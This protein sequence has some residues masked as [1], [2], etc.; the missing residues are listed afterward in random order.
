MLGRIAKGEDPAGERKAQAQRDRA[1]LEAALDLYERALE[2]RHVV[3]RG[4]YLS[5]LR[6][7]LLKPLGNVELQEI[8]RAT[9]A[10]RI[11]KI[12]AGRRPGAAKELKTRASVFLSWAVDEGMINANPLAGW[13][14]QRRTKAER[15]DRPGRALAD[16]ELPIFWKAAEAEG[17]PFGPYLQML[18]LTGQ[19]RT[20]TSLMRWSDVDLAAGEWRIPA[21][22]TKSGRTHRVP[23]PARAVAI[24]EKLPRLARS[25]Y[26]SPAGGASR[27]RA[28]QSVCRRSTVRPSRPE[29]RTGHRMTSDGPCAQDWAGSASTRSPPS[30]CYNHAISEELQAVYDRGDYWQ[31]RV[32][33][34]AQWA[35]HVMRLVEGPD[36]VVKFPAA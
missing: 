36:K 24:L 9:V 13:R 34:A 22:V 12:T 35:D 15:L 29:W 26:G 17:W 8:D 14:R 16:S 33:A 11:R 5:L 2:H 6:R 21:E 18:L 31:K 7:E 30:F 27:S 20:E 23:L 19:R 4:E 3:K 10:E 32:E 28:G 1:R 25:Q